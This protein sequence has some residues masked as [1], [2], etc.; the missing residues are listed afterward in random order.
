METNTQQK[1]DIAFED[2]AKA[3]IRICKILT[4]EKVEKADK[5]YKLTVDTGID[6]RVVVSAIA[7]KLTPE[8]IL[9]KNIPFILNLPV[10]SIR[11]IESHGMIL[12]AGN[13]DN[14]FYVLSNENAAPGTVV[15]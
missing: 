6:N 14:D 15:I 11:G 5:L 1:S 2:F 10:R 3:D 7:H 13:P 9:N 4:V 12:L 8:Q